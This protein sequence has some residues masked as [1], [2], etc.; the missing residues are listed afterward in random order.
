MFGSP[1]SD[2]GSFDSYDYRKM[3]ERIDKKMRY[4]GDRTGMA[5]L[6][7]D[8][9]GLSELASPHSA[10]MPFHEMSDPSAPTHELHDSQFSRKVFPSASVQRQSSPELRHPTDSESGGSSL[11]QR[12]KRKPAVDP[13]YSTPQCTVNGWNNTNESGSRASFIAGKASSTNDLFGVRTPGTRRGSIANS[14]VDR[15]GDRNSCP[16]FVETDISR[17]SSDSSGSSMEFPRVETFIS[18]SP[19]DKSLYLDRPLPTLPQRESLN[20]NHPLP[21]IPSSNA[22]QTSPTKTMP[23]HRFS[24]LNHGHR[25]SSGKSVSF[26]DPEITEGALPTDSSPESFWTA[27]DT[28][29][30]TPNRPKPCHMSSDSTDIEMMEDCFSPATFTPA[31]GSPASDV[32]SPSS[33]NHGFLF[34]SSDT[35]PPISPIAR[36]TSP[37][38]DLTDPFTDTYEGLSLGTAKRHEN[39]GNPF[40]YLVP[41]PLK[42]ATRKLKHTRSASNTPEQGL[43]AQ[44]ANPHTAVSSVS[45][46]QWTEDN[47]RQ[48]NLD[49]FHRGSEVEELGKPSICTHPY[50]SGTQSSDLADSIHSA[51][52]DELIE[53]EAPSAMIQ[54]IMAQVDTSNWWSLVSLPSVPSSAPSVRSTHTE[55]SFMD[56]T[57]GTVKAEMPVHATAPVGIDAGDHGFHKLPLPVD[58]SNPS[59]PFSSS[60]DSERKSG[61]AL[62]CRRQMNVPPLPL[63]KSDV[64]SSGNRIGAISNHRA[65]RPTPRSLTPNR[66]FLQSHNRKVSRSGGR[67]AGSESSVVSM[68]QRPLSPPAT[69][70][71]LSPTNTP[72]HCFDHGALLVTHSASK[73]AQV[74]ELQTLVGVW[75][76]DWMKRLKSD[77]ELQLRCSELPPRALF[78]KGIRTLRKCFLGRFA[79]I[80]E[81]VFALLTLAFAAA[82]LLQRQQRF[83]CQDTFHDEALQWQH[84]LSDKEDKILFLKAMDCW[85][86]LPE[87]QPTPL[88]NKSRHTSYGSMTSQ[89]S[90]K[91]NDQTDPLEMLRDNEVLKACTG[92]L[93]GESML[94]HFKIHS[95]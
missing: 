70:T 64:S 24:V 33:P 35:F 40:E 89:E 21:A 36:N 31:T 29:W 65:S 83:R 41:L 91:C 48:E 49:P 79:L 9:A 58:G 23:S 5:E 26:N 11:L 42:S 12:L 53:C 94:I 78:E 73:H 25:L 27:R 17:E 77:P 43:P 30:E 45:G 7:D 74:E 87:L 51:G 6:G 71:T 60:H 18:S 84:A 68:N 28:N 38:A 85:W 92:F 95:E 47:I 80:L 1:E 20:L 72:P 63:S 61:A 88:L 46:T 14:N 62:L 39:A 86:P 3:T 37:L 44:F 2:M 57:L 69:F 67:V 13:R 19:R 16:I 59:P 32:I 10:S 22:T 75:N 55:S 81:D 8:D 82:F 90:L 50:V 66:V 4:S 93:D 15:K 56:G 76:N 52:I 34:P 54:S